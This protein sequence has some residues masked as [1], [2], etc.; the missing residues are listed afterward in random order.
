MCDHIKFL[1]IMGTFN[2]LKLKGHKKCVPINLAQLNSFCLVILF[3]RDLYP[4]VLQ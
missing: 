4:L 2:R 3:A 1:N